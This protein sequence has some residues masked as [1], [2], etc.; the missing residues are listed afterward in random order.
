MFLRHE[1][2]IYITILERSREDFSI[3]QMLIFY[4]RIWILLTIPSLPVEQQQKGEIL[5]ESG[6]FSHIEIS[7]G[8]LSK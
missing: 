3:F 5:L 1:T 6:H 2:L 4:I 8:K 7:P